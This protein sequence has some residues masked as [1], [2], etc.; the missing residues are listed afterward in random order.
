MKLDNRGLEPPQPMMRTLAALD[1]LPEGEELIINNDRRP[2]FLYE[3][4]DGRGYKHET[5]ELE[6]GSFQITIRKS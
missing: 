3:E 4:L 1:E 2:M 6:D 5:I